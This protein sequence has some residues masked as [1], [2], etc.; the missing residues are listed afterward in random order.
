MLSAISVSSKMWFVFA[1]QLISVLLRFQPVTSYSCEQADWQVSLDKIG[2]SKCPKDNT[3]LRGLWR[4]E[5]KYGDERVGRIEYGKC[6]SATDPGYA[7]QP[8][9]CSNANWQSTLD[10]WV[11][12]KMKIT[13]GEAQENIA[14]SKLKPLEI[15]TFI[16]YIY[17]IYWYQST[18]VLSHWCHTLIGYATLC[19][20]C[21]TDSE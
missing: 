16:I 1:I 5:R 8:A 4:H 7:N 14:W 11:I 21:C 12:T 9:T 6:C 3:Y 17:T 15:Y 19:L 10:G 18:H 20:L 2:W 13:D